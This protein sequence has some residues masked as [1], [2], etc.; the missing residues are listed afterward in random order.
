V[1]QA[2]M[3]LLFQALSPAAIVVVLWWEKSRR[4]VTSFTIVRATKANALNL[5]HGKRFLRRGSPEVLKQ[6]SFDDE[7]L[8]WVTEA[9]RQCH[10]DEKQYH[11]EAIDRLQKEYAHLRDRIDGMYLGK[12]DGRISAE[13]FDRKASGWREEQGRI[14]RQIE[15]QEEAKASYMDEG[16]RIL[17]LSQRAPELFQKQ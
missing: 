17:E 7:V 12:L 10:A 3:N 9:F 15:E 1:E 5:T 8:E 4:G 16:I 13:V 14:L 6:I 2:N 11:E